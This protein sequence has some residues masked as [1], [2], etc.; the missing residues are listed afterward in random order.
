MER[1]DRAV[2][3]I[4]KPLPRDEDFP[5]LRGLGNYTDDIE[6]PEA[7]YA[8][9]VRSPH[10]HARITHIAT[11]AAARMPGVLA[12]VTSREWAQASLGAVPCQF[13]IRATAHR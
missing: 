5:I 4:G 9:F 1:P 6:L 2:S 11:N 13:P 10:A 7:A 8:A 12:V 3:Y